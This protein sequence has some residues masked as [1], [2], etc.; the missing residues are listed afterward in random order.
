M[1]LIRLGYAGAIT[2]FLGITR[3][4]FGGKQVTSLEYEAY[5]SM[6]IESMRNIAGSVI[7]K[8]CND[9]ICFF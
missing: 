9:E 5:D 6:A 4:I 3:D 1:F 2:I 8:L 7:I